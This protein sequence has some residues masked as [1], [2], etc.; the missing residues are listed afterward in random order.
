MSI[1]NTLVLLVFI[2]SHLSGLSQRI[3]DFETYTNGDDLPAL[4]DSSW[5]TNS[6]GSLIVSD[7]SGPFK[8]FQGDLYALTGNDVTAK[9]S[10][11]LAQGTWHLNVATIVGGTDAW[12]RNRQIVI[13][14]GG[15]VVLNTTIDNSSSDWVA[16]HLTFNSTGAWV[17]IELRHNNTGGLPMGIDAFSLS[18]PRSYY[19]SSSSGNDSQAGTEIGPWQTLTKLSDTTLQPGDTVY[20]KKGDTFLGHYVVKGSG[21]ALAP[22][23]FKSYGENSAQPVISGSGHSDGGGDYK[24]AI[25]INNK[26]HMVFEDLEIQNHRTQSRAGVDDIVSFGML[27]QNTSNQVKRHY[28]FKNMTFKNVYGLYWVDPSDQSAFNGFEVSG[29]TFKSGSAGHIDD[30]IVEDSDFTDLQRLGVHIKNTANANSGKYNTNMVFRR[31]TFF[32]IGGTCILPIRAK[33]CLIEHNIFDQPGARTNT[34]M[35]GR[36][37]AVW[38]WHCVNTLIQYNQSINAKGI[39]DSHGIHVDHSNSDTFIQYNFMKDCEGGF[40]E[41]LGGNERAVYR[42][43]ISLN[44]GWRENPNWQNSN[45]TLWLSDK[46][47]GNGGHESLDSYIYNNT[48]I[49]NKVNAEA[50]DTAIDI[51]AVNTRIFN[52]IFYAVNGSGIGNQQVYVQDPN[53]LMTHNLFFGNI[54][55]S[56]KNK[57]NANVLEDPKFNN[58]DLEHPYGFQI[59]NPSG[60]INAGRAFTGNYEHPII[61]VE[62]SSIFNHVEALPTTDFF[63]QT[64]TGDNTPNIGASNAKNGEIL[65][66]K[67]DAS[68]STISIKNPVITDAIEIYGITQESNYILYDLVGRKKQAGSLSKTNSRIKLNALLPAGLY[69]L[70]LEINKKVHC[71]KLLITAH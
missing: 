41:I 3:D 48:V 68:T 30:I 15:T 32:Q 10:L 24:E 12:R 26:D 60:T 4:S 67:T 57:G 22:I 18:Q 29:L 36:G 13:R 55:Q 45:H 52:N 25:V 9:Y 47:G 40:V 56:F 27:I 23:T 51:D 28:R 70:N 1:K 44:D 34:K 37:S 39:L 38:N 59:N 33:N 46:I 66:F 43:N 11:W 64:L 21:A 14:V 62:A 2:M 20:F 50:F 69:M 19:I 63:G 65:S 17:I 71:F 42:F 6:N 35:I 61:P 16:S 31:N 5:G 53:L 7:D 58:T 49:I 8:P 54:N